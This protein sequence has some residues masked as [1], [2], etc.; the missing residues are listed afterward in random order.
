TGADK[1]AIEGVGRR[2]LAPDQAAK[3]RAAFQ[4]RA[5]VGRLIHAAAARPQCVFDR[6]WSQ[7]AAI[8]FPEFATM[9]NAVRWISAESALQL[10][11]GK[12]LDAI[13]TDGLGFRV[14]RHAANDPMLIAYLVANA[15]DA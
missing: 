7:G 5:D 10:Y 15:L 2:M 14:A 12:P 1:I 3:L 6:Q 13:K 8:M 11:D 4:H 9:R